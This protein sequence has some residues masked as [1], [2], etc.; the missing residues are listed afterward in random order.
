MRFPVSR[1]KYNLLSV[2]LERCRK[3]ASDMNKKHIQE[4]DKLI[5]PMVDKFL[6][7]RIKPGE[8]D[9]YMIQVRMDSCWVETCLLHGDSQREI[10]IISEIMSY[11]IAAELDRALRALNIIRHKV[12]REKTAKLLAS[13]PECDDYDEDYF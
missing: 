10:E 4:R 12:M 1:K 11:N 8:F 6:K 13:M 2:E 3:S 9:T 5:K 7:V